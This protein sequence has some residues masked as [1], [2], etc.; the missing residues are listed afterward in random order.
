M[1]KMNIYGVLGLLL[2]II[3]IILGFVAIITESIEYALIYLFITMFCALGVLYFYCTKCKCKDT[4][5]GH[6]FPRKITKYLPQRKQTDYTFSDK[7]VTGVCIFLVFL[8]PQLW[9]IRNLL[10]FTGFWIIVTIRAFLLFKRICPICANDICPLNPHFPKL[11][12]F[13]Q[14]ISN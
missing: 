1:S 9:L 12:E 6:I 5:C 2:I 13:G 8:F 11:N 10:L 14:F 3:A 7:L 4:E